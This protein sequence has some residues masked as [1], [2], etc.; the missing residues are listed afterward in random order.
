MLEFVG[1]VRRLR[2]SET[3]QKIDGVRVQAREQLACVGL[4]NGTK[5]APLQPG[6][7]AFCMKRVAA[8]ETSDLLHGFPVPQAYSTPPREFSLTV[9][10]VRRQR[11]NALL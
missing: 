1:T 4:T 9:K 2:R 7:N 10:D 3:T 5:V 8:L 6:V 11:R